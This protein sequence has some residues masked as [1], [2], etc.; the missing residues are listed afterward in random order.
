MRLPDPIANTTTEAYLA[1]K[2]G[3]LESGDLKP[4]L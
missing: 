2:A 4:K 3:V 1:Y